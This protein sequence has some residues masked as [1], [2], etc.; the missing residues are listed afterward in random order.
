M[1][2]RL[3]RITASFLPAVGL[4]AGCC[5]PVSGRQAG[6]SS[7]GSGC[8][9]CSA[10][11]MFVAGACYDT[12]CLG[13]SCGPNQVC[14]QDQCE[15]TSC[16]GVV[17]AA[18]EICDAQGQCLPTSCGGVSCLP[19]EGCDDGGCAVAACV[20]VRCGADQLCANGGCYSTSCGPM[21]CAGGDV[22]VDGNCAPAYCLTPNLCPAG[23][24]CTGLGCSSTSCG[25]LQC[26]P[27]NVCDPPTNE[28]ISA[29]CYDAN[30]PPG[31][32]CADGVCWPTSCGP[33]APCASGDVCVDDVCLAD[34]HGEFCPG[35]CPAAGCPTGGGGTSSG[36]GSAGANGGSGPGGNGSGGNGSAS[37]GS[38][39]GGSGGSGSTGQVPAFDLVALDQVENNNAISAV[40]WPDGHLE[41][42]AL[43]LS[44]STEHVWTNGDTNNW[45]APRSFSGSAECG[46]ASVLNAEVTSQAEVFGPGKQETQTAYWS[47]RAWHGL[48]RFGGGRVSQ[49]A[50]LRW[51][52]DRS[53]PWMDGR[54]EVF[55]L[56]PKGGIWHRYLNPSTGR[57]STSSFED[58][59]E[60]LPRGD[61]PDGVDFRTGVAAILDSSGRA[62]IAAV[63]MYGQAWYDVSH[64][65]DGSGWAGWKPIGTQF[66]PRLSSRPSAVRQSSGTIRLFARG[67]DGELYGSRSTSSGFASFE[68]IDGRFH[69]NGEPS[70]AIE[71]GTVEV[72]VRGRDGK[73]WFTA[74]GSNGRFA[75][76]KEVP[77]NE[78][79]SSDPFA[80]KRPDRNGQ[81]QLFA[82]GPRNHLLTTL[83]AAAPSGWSGWRTVS[84]GI[85]PCPAP[86]V[87]CPNG[88]GSYCGGH[89]IPGASNE[90]YQCDA[91]GVL[92]ANAQIC[93]KGCLPSGL[94]G[95]D[96]CKQAVGGTSGGTTGGTGGSV[97]ASNADC[98]QDFGSC[99][100]CVTASGCGSVANQCANAAL[101][102][103]SCTTTADCDPCDGGGWTCT[104]CA[105]GGSSCQAN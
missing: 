31:T 61:L 21:S 95:Q 82:V 28:C 11:Q 9:A 69:F 73:V 45:H 53:G 51:N 85:D 20:G 105:A 65:A 93:P 24:L 49:L 4:L 91:S 47:S 41:A 38:G 50:T 10:S 32:L 101:V 35:T 30:C 62:V 23:T 15:P 58:W 71:N 48:Q 8:P 83:H 94:G 67:M 68:P 89:G 36:Q 103:Q 6:S 92:A 37:N 44:G 96:T 100:V 42:F 57:W 98:T 54:P 17:C 60:I 5:G 78:I 22:C 81:V 90:L 104:P 63:D 52:D 80:W 75:S 25:G 29:A 66:H 14:V 7:G 77:G 76:F 16:L 59:I 18:D 72:F 39:S 55:G 13:L 19:G 43:G 79:V 84:Q 2:I 102:G 70:A 40:T 34:C 3:L 56:G 99:A 86:Q 46:V 74:L 88:Q 64:T 33:S 1:S 26:A 27:G 97:C 12:S 87:G